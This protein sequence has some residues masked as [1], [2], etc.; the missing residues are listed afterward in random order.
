MAIVVG[1]E[2]LGDESRDRLAHR[3]GDR[4]TEHLFGGGV[5]QDHMLVGVDGYDRVHGGR[6]DT[7]EAPL[8]VGRF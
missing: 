8:A 7:L 6:Q 3:L 5:E 4:T 2:P 1:P